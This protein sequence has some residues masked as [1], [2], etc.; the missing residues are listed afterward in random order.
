MTVNPRFVPGRSDFFNSLTPSNQKR[1]GEICVPKSVRKK[2]VLFREGDKGRALYFCAK[3]SI[4]L[5]QTASSGQE[6]VIKVIRPGE[7][8]AEAV[9]FEKERYPVTAVALETGLIYVIPRTEFTRLLDDPEFRDDF[10][11]NLMR[12]LR[13][14][15]DQV[16]VLTTLDVEDRLFRFM[17]ERF[18]DGGNIVTAMSKK[19]VAAAIGTT[20]ETLSRL[21]QKLNE[22]GRLSWKGRRIQIGG[23]TR[24]QD[25]VD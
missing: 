22:A 20:P 24:N 11:S 3:G 5:H 10:I 12:K 1:L 25:L 18:G 21:L 19:D 15:A 7:L 13:Y 6:A 8:F 14:L 23:E 17:K 9:L 2:E 4:R 16:R